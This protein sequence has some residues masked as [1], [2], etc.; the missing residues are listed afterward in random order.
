M[1]KFTKFFAITMF[2][3]LILAVGSMYISIVN[4]EG[5]IRPAAV[6]FYTIVLLGYSFTLFYV[7]NREKQVEIEQIELEKKLALEELEKHKNELEKHKKELEEVKK[8]FEEY[9]KKIKES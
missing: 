3:L 1:I 4:N 2:F 5:V 6:V 8:K 7:W 9:E